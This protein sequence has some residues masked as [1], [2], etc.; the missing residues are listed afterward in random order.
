MGERAPGQRPVAQPGSSSVDQPDYWWHRARAGLLEA[1]LGGFLGRPADV[2]DVGSA[3]GPSVGWMRGEHQLS[4]DLDPRGLAPG[5]GVLASLEALPFADE[6]FDVVGAFD[7][8]EHCPDEARALAEVVRVLRPGGRL[9]CSVPAYEWAWTDHDVRAGHHRRYTRRRLLSAV[10]GAG[11]EPLRCTHGFAG[12]FPLFAL[13]RASRRVRG[14]RSGGAQ[15]LPQVSPLLDRVL[16][17]LCGLEERV[18]RRHDLPFG[19]S[20]FLAARRPVPPRVA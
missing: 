6:S 3:D 2:L 5:R 4:V 19:S 20:V 18:L 8:V 15:Q 9:L 14:P 10:V 12:V 17:G 11:L 13:E 1:A 16:T 7:V